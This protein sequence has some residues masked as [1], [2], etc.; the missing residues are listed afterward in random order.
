MVD[1]Q[2]SIGEADAAVTI[3]GVGLGIE[4]IQVFVFVEII[5]GA[6]ETKGDREDL[7]LER[8]GLGVKVAV[9]YAIRCKSSGDRPPKYLG[10]RHAEFTAQ[11]PVR[12]VQ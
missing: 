12:K 1:S 8:L 11:S 9:P 7:V 4:V 3:D 6:S 5:P 10:V 2:M